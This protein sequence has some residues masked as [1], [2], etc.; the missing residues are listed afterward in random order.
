M[1][2]SQQQHPGFVGQLVPSGSVGA[3]GT[4]VALEA[5]GGLDVLVQQG[6]LVRILGKA[7]RQGVNPWVRKEVDHVEVKVDAAGLSI[8]R[9][10]EIVLL[11]EV[12]HAGELVQGLVLIGRRRSGWSAVVIVTR[13]ATTPSTA[14]TA[15][16]ST[17]S[18]PSPATPTTTTSTASTA[19]RVVVGENAPGVKVVGTATVI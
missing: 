17:P 14:S 19:S 9:D 7:V 16:T 1:L 3:G 4:P 5:T 12:V 18:P 11:I 6:L 15:A 10:V 2:I 13:A 8:I